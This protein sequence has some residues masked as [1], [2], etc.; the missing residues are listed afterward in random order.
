MAIKLF[1]EQEIL[2]FFGEEKINTRYS[3]ILKCLN[4]YTLHNKLQLVNSIENVSY[5]ICLDSFNLFLNFTKPFI[6]KDKFAN[7]YKIAANLI[8]TVI[9]SNI[10]IDEQPKELENRKKNVDFGLYM[11][12]LLLALNET[13][14]PNW[15]HKTLGTNVEIVNDDFD[16]IQEHFLYYLTH[17]NVTEQTQ[18]PIV[19]LSIF[20]HS[21]TL[22]WQW[23]GNNKAFSSAQ[24]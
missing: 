24:L 4:D 22:W 7:K 20:L 10:F 13:K 8:Y 12:S 18:P 21:F 15:F 23:D 16:T 9:L 6:D 2:D 17:L 11:A 5:T 19:L 14:K 3:D 1:S